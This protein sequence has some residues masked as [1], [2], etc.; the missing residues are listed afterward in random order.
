MFIRKCERRTWFALA[1]S[2]V[3]VAGAMMTLPQPARAYTDVFY[4]YD[5]LPPDLY[6][7]R[8]GSSNGDGAIIGTLTAYVTYDGY[9]HRIIMAA[10]SGNDE[11]DDCVSFA[12]PSPDG[13]Y[14]R[15]DGDSNSQLS[16]YYKD[17]GSS[18]VRGWVWFM[19]SKRCDGGSTTLRDGLFIHSQGYSGWDDS[20]YVSEGCIKINQTDRGWLEAVQRVSYDYTNDRL[21]VYGNE[22]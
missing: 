19:D 1:I 8:G 17:S 18:V 9:R 10:G 15:S 12:G 3:L 4:S 21:Y 2:L 20:N 5:N 22:Q 14:G 13:Y 16:L 11:L 7:A 6:F